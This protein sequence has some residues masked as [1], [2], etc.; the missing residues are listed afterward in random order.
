MCRDQNLISATDGRTD[1]RSGRTKI[2]KQGVGRPFLGPAKIPLNLLTC[3]D[4]STL[5]L[6]VRGLQLLSG[7]RQVLCLRRNAGG[8]HIQTLRLTD[9]IGLGGDS[10]K[11]VHGA[12]LLTS[13]NT[14]PP[15]KPK[16]TNKTDV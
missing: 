9:Y 16:T 15:I 4:S 6:I 7:S 8:T 10:V 5:L 1:G 2:E 3:A 14:K 13:P 12:K 11:I